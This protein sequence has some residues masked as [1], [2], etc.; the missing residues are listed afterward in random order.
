MIGSN[1]LYVCTGNICRSPMAEA[2][3]KYFIAKKGTRYKL[4]VASC[5]ISAA[6]LGQ[7]ADRRTLKI[8]ENNKI[9]VI[10]SKARM[11]QKN[12]DFVAFDT[13]VAMD[14]GHV[15]ALKNI[16]GKQFRPKQ[17]YLFTDIMPARKGQDIEDPFFGTLAGF[18]EIYH[19]LY[20]GCQ[21]WADW[22]IARNKEKQLNSQ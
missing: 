6:H 4:T 2:L 12:T 10:P 22:I 11:I 21:L 17:I 19:L 9:N 1:I 8:L 14:L 3:T 15:I 5:G 20:E 7:S 18:N 16:A 13:I